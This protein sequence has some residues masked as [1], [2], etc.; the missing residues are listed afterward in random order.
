MYLFGLEGSGFIISLGLIL[1]ISGAIMF[2]CLRR[3][4]ILE[5][6]ILDQGRILQSFIIKM[7]EQELPPI[8]RQLATDVAI[9]AAIQQSTN[10][11]SDNISGKIEVS[12]NETV[13]DE[14]SDSVESEEESNYDSEDED[15]VH[16]EGSPENEI[17][18]E[19]K[20]DIKSE[21]IEENS[22]VKI[23][24]IEDLQKDLMSVES[25]NISS[26][27]S[28]SHMDNSS[29]DDGEMISMTIKPDE[30]DESDDL[31]KKKLFSKMKVAELRTLVFN[32]GLVE[33]MDLANKIKKDNLI[34]MLQE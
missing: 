17:S 16:S 32:N 27:T 24:S 11:D 21:L 19:T 33:N 22:S 10:Q 28:D 25:I 30:P 18:D 7:Q 34:K 1:L 13:T 12:D 20:V 8:N 2:Y 4:S 29:V 9:N 23:I 31:S 14:D 5:K 26:E 3:F 15:S 6:S